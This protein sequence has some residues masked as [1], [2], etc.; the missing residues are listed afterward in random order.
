MTM[1][2][3]EYVIFAKNKVPES[4]INKKYYDAYVDFLDSISAEK[5]LKRN[6]PPFHDVYEKVFANKELDTITINDVCAGV[7]NL[8]KQLTLTLKFILFLIDNN[9]TLAPELANLNQVRHIVISTGWSVEKVLEVFKE[10]VKDKYYI[11]KYKNT[12]CM[13]HI[14]ID[15]EE[16]RNIIKKFI[17]EY[18]DK[19]S[20]GE[21]K[22]FTENIARGVNIPLTVESLNYDTY[23]SHLRY[24]SNFKNTAMLTLTNY[25]YYFVG[26]NYK[27][28]IFKEQGLSLL[29]I[30]KLGFPLYVLDGFEVVLYN[31]IEETPKADKWIFIH[32]NVNVQNNDITKSGLVM[33]DFTKVENATYREWAKF[34]IWKKVGTTRTLGKLALLARFC[35]FISDLKSGK[36]YSIYTKPTS[37]ISIS[38]SEVMAYKTMV[39]MDNNISNQTK[40]NYLTFIGRFLGFLK[41]ESIT[42]LPTGI[43]YHLSNFS[44]EANNNTANCIPDEDLRQLAALMKKNSSES[45]EKALYYLLFY[46]LL[47]TELRISQVLT[48]EVDC[49]RETSKPNEYVLVSKTKTSAG[50]EVEQPITLYVKKHIDEII[51]LTQPLRE[52]CLNKDLVKYLFLMQAADYPDAYI[53]LTNKRF[54]RYLRECCDE[55][56]LKRYSASN[57]R[58]T[59]MTKAEEFIIRNQLSD[60]Q[61]N[62][63]SGHKSP[64]TDNKHYIDTDI[65]DLLESVHGII[66]GDVDINGQIIAFNS[67]VAKP[68]NAVSNGCGYCGRSSCNEF[69]MLDCMMCKSFVTTP[70]RLP[71]FQEQVKILD[72][73]IEIATIP[74]DK[75]DLVNIKRLY[76]SFIS[77][78]VALKQKQSEEE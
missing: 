47:E 74:H 2:K 44:K 35:N 37:D 39:M 11:Y 21:C 34:F 66:I 52:N 28:D 65:K 76:L 57:L 70:D 6:I 29:N 27:P 42:T 78:I 10:P 41:A 58:D 63:L 12:Y 25:F 7:S 62:I 54:W 20:E 14:D 1:T 13:S 53:I 46:I 72:H 51:K 71:Y 49:V 23:I 59:H 19:T 24:F 18:I 31:P 38:I 4:D 43:E 61:Q 77:K 17:G 75:E 60:M 68:E 32:N 56:G 33:L 40:A 55:L 3:E 5:T 73:K 50:E 26:I 16:F 15:D 9:A 8:K 22:I 64:T 48:L 45:V 69:T 67:D 36:T 30:T